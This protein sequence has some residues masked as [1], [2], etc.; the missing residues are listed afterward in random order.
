[1]SSRDLTPVVSDDERASAGGSLNVGWARFAL[2]FT[3]ILT[4][5]SV[6]STYQRRRA[7]PSRAEW[8]AA[9][10]AVRAHWRVGDRVTW[11]PT[12]AEE[13]KL[14]LH[15]LSPLILPERGRVDLG[16]ARRLWVL[17]ALGYQSAQLV[18]DPEIITLQPLTVSA[19]QPQIEESPVSLTLFEVGGARVQHDLIADLEHVERVHVSRRTLKPSHARRARSTRSI[20]AAENERCD[21]WALEG[22]HCAPR[23]AQARISV[24]RCL[25]QTLSAKLKRRSKRRHLYTLDRRRW[26]PYVDCRLNPTEHVSRDWRVIG[27]Q[28]RRCIWLAP[29]RGREVS[30]DWTVTAHDDDHDALWLGWGWSD[31]AVRHPFRASRAE[32][33]QLRIQRGA[34]IIWDRALSPDLGWSRAQLPLPPQDEMGPPVPITIS[35]RPLRGV[36]DAALCVDLSVRRSRLLIKR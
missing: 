29:H 35:V 15:G 12:W 6:W 36:E 23:S 22:W 7:V 5:W 30:I 20:R 27:E 10:A 4:G 3:V 13:A 8:S 17:S 16:R 2:L 32:P 14:S 24:S 19:T 26:L 1:M 33:L 21:L 9:A 25:N 34:E 11:Y 28:P 31:L 18:S